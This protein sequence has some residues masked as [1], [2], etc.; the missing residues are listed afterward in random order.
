MTTNDVIKRL[1]KLFD[2][3]I[4]RKT[5]WGKIE[6]KTIFHGC[7][8]VVMGEY[9]DAKEKGDVTITNIKRTDRHNRE[10]GNE[11]DQFS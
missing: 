6:V 10:V 7:I 1:E 5:G 11:Y 2:E 8:R 3:E 4:E 9:I